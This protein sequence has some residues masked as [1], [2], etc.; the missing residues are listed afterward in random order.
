MALERLEPHFSTFSIYLH[1]SMIESPQEMRNTQKYRRIVPVCS[2]FS[3][4]LGLENG[5]Q[6]RDTMMFLEIIA[7]SC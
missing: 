1:L 2:M 6:R 5:G 4:I 7:V 3:I